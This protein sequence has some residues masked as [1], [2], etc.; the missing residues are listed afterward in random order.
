[1]SCNCQQAASIL[2]RCYGQAQPRPLKTKKRMVKQTKKRMILLDDDPSP[3]KATGEKKARTPPR[4]QPPKAMG[5]K[6]ARKKRMVLLDD[7]PDDQVVEL[8][9][10]VANL[11]KQVEERVTGRRVQ[12]QFAQPVEAPAH[13]TG[14]LKRALEAAN[15]IEKNIRK[16]QDETIMNEADA[17]KDDA[18]YEQKRYDLLMKKKKMRMQL[19]KAKR[20]A[21]NLYSKDFVQV[22]N[23]VPVALTIKGKSKNTGRKGKRRGK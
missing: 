6:K 8:Q 13:A 21:E 14:A 5:E 7:D 2:G 12:P 20:D 9:R 16:Y 1:M 3:P 23:K 10:E 11:R 18:E 22:G 15:R 17:A 4:K 19:N